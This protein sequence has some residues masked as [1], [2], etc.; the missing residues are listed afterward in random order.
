MII[1]FSKKDD[2]D[3]FISLKADHFYLKSMYGATR[4]DDLTL[5]LNDKFN[6][7]LIGEHAT[8]NKINL[9]TRKDLEDKPSM[10]I[11]INL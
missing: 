3:Y 10:K 2:L 5:Q 1:K 9:F 7:I 4:I 11:E 8:H 6:N